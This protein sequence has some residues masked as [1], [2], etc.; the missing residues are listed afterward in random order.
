MFT[1][2]EY[3]KA[4]E[5]FK[6]K[7]MVEKC[8]LSLIEKEMLEFAKAPRLPWIELIIPAKMGE[9]LRG[10]I[11]DKY[12][13]SGWSLVASTQEDQETRFVFCTAEMMQDWFNFREKIGYDDSRWLVVVRKEDVNG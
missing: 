11:S 13:K 1:P 9:E 6:T 3:L 12:V 8:A 10:N 4:V 2:N 7:E 5:E